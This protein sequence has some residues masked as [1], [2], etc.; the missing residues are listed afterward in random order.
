MNTQQ[1][2]AGNEGVSENHEMVNGRN[3]ITPQ[4]GSGVFKGGAVVRPPPSLWSDRKIFLA[5]F[6]L[7]CKLHFAIEP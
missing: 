4:T 1:I 6:A 3:G 7:F 5:N 2:K